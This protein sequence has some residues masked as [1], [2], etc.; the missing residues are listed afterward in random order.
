MSPGDFDFDGSRRLEKSP[1][2]HRGL[3]GFTLIELLVVIAI[4]AILGALLLP[5]LARAKERGKRAQCLSN[6]R[7]VGI[8]TILY[9]DD[10]SGMVLPC[11][12][13][14]VQVELTPI[15][16]QLSATLGLLITSNAPSVW[17][18]PDLPKLPFYDNYGGY[19]QWSIGYQ[20]FGGIAT[21]MNPAGI[22]PSCS[23]VNLRQSQP[24]WALAAD[25]VMQIDGAWGTSED[26]LGRADW[27]G[28]P[29]HKGG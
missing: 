16:T 15:D 29:P 2:S 26:N 7:Q 25:M 4:I 1:A 20:Y 23:P 24:H 14:Q 11:I 12:S 18:C 6:L 9:A 21:W 19:N 27:D 28:V 13:G 3:R 5:A 17:A 22:F 10:N 8:A